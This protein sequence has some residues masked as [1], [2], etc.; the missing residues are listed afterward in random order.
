MIGA[1]KHQVESLFEMTPA[2]EK[3]ID[4]NAEKTIKILSAIACLLVREH[5]V[6]CIMPK[7][8]S[9][10][11]FLELEASV[12]EPFKPARE[13]HPIQRIE[14]APKPTIQIT[15]NQSQDE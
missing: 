10:N 2:W 5:E 12:E 3:L 9:A 11:G 6:I 4:P 8:L 14:V 1:K 15:R 13:G 7:K